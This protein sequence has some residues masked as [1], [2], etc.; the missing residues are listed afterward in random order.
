MT[1]VHDLE[2]TGG[3]DEYEVVADKAMT[4]AKEQN[5]EVI[6]KWVNWIK[7]YNQRDEVVPVHYFRFN[8]AMTEIHIRAQYL[9]LELM[10]EFRP[11]WPRIIK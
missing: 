1:T 7:P 3:W 5:R 9:N 8:P 2:G 6:V 4:L 10:P 11:Q